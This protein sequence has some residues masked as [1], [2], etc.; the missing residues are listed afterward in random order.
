MAV[1]ASL[2]RF[3]LSALHALLWLRASLAFVFGEMRA[4]LIVL[5]KHKGDELDRVAADARSLPRLPLHLAL[6]VQEEGAWPDDLARVAA[7]AFATGVRYV[8]LYDHSGGGVAGG[9]G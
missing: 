6:V 1:S 4:S 3:T 7:W 5:F 9:R 8:S 2:Y